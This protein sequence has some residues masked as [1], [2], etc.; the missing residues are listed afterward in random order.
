MGPSDLHVIGHLR[1][2]L[3][4]VRFA[5]DANMRQAVMFWLQTFDTSVLCAGIQDLVSQW[6]KCLSVNHDN[7]EA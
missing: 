5:A 4:G 6:D 3:A 2:H 7:V 1:K